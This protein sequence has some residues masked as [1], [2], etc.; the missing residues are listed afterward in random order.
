MEK[1]EMKVTVAR[2][3]LVMITGNYWKAVILNQFLYWTQVQGK[4]IKMI[5]EE[6]ER[7]R[8]DG[9]SSD[10]A[11]T[12]GWVYKTADDLADELLG[13]LERRAIRRYLK[14]LIEDGFL[15]QRRN[16]HH[17]WDRTLQ[18]RVNLGMVRDKLIACGLPPVVG[19]LV[20]LYQSNGTNVPMERSKSAIQE[21]E[22]RQTIPEITTETTKNNNILSGK[23]DDAQNPPPKEKEKKG[24]GVEEVVDYLNEKAGTKYRP[25][26][27]ATQQH[28]KAR[29]K[30][31]F[32]LEDFK[33]VINRK[34]Q[35][36]RGTEYEKYLRPE[37]LFG[38]KFE[39][40]LNQPTHN[41]RAGTST[42]KK[43]YV[44]EVLF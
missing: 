5:D 41:G 21:D 8:Q 1:R 24:E 30:E 38:A 19:R 27:K 31:G 15:L 11:L 40:Y 9:E 3:E 17:K 39:S 18:Y 44:T 29:M 33:T 13:G 32:T 20:L 36:W 23:P 37:T 10:F 7:R 14:A 43:K 28:I 2:E 4:A 25:G 22:L 26:T 35:E 6:N 16:P 42:G 12:E 34:V